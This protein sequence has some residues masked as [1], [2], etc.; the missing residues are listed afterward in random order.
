M[1][2]RLIY[3]ILPL[4]AIVML[5]ASCKED[6]P[7]AEMPIQVDT[8]P[9]L[10]EY[11]DLPPPVITAD[12]ELTVEKVKLGRMLFYETRLS[13]DGSMSCSSCHQQ[14]NA[15]S[16]SSRFSIGVAGQPGGRHA[17]AVFNMAW[18]TNEFFWDGRAHL[19]RD[20]SLLPIQDPLEMKESLPGIIS[21]LQVDSRYRE[22]FAR[23]FGGDKITAFRISLALEQF[24][25][26]IVSVDSKYDRFLRNEV[27]LSASEDRGRELF[28]TE[29]NPFFPSL[30]G[31]DCAH[32]HSG[33]NF[34][35]DRYL[36]NGLDAQV[37][38]T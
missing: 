16:D 28:F 20:Q 19:L 2:S 11:G 36:N 3:K 31:A 10:L 32:C 1:K 18:N 35:N 17:M 14:E 30:S 24:M 29:Y 26:S 5:W 8:T 6:P 34:E 23:A 15:F 12:N 38:F 37:D 22:Q 9:Y 4:L 33:K 21:K 13:L 25:N 7:I 27:T